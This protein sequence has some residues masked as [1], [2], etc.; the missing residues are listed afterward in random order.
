MVKSF[1]L[2]LAVSTALLAGVALAGFAAIAWWQMRDAKIGALERQIRDQAEREI[3]RRWLADQW[4]RHEYNMGRVFGTLT[5]QQSLLLVQDSQ[6]M[7]FRS[8]HWP[9][10]LAPDKLPWPQPENRPE[11]LEPHDT[12]VS[13]VA[14]PP[15]DG[16]E[17]SNIQPP[18]GMDAQEP[19]LPPPEDL[20]GGLSPPLG[21]PPRPRLSAFTVISLES[22]GKHWRFG[23]ASTPREKLAIG[24]DLAVIEAE[25]TEMRNAFLLA[26]PLALGFIGLGAWFL[27]G[28]ALSPIRS[29]T[30]TM[31]SVTAK[32]LDQRVALRHEDEEFRRLIQVFNGMLERLE[33][34]FLQATRFSGDAAHELKTPLAILQGQIE[35]AM[36]QCEAGS[37]IQTHLTDILDE[38]QRLGTIS[39]KLLLLSLADAGRL[40]LHVIRLDLSQVLE[41]LLED[42]QMLA[43]ELDVSGSIA[44]GLMV[45]ADAALLRQVLHNLLGNAIKY[46][47][48]NGWIRISASLDDG[49]V[50]VSIVNSSAGI[51]QADHERIFER[52]YRADPAHNR[53]VEGAGLGLSLSREIVRAH[54]GDLVLADSGEG[55]VR[56]VVS[57]AL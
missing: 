34:S 21:P 40:R 47:L 11:P 53:Q 22:G 48:P 24:V 25:M 5:I 2:R 56:F 7:V 26:A 12:G 13:T 29:L 18:P 35:R 28:H 41:D 52:F 17:P 16:M 37:P 32:G 46:N 43:P 36:A 39:R 4:T 3:S 8:K 23:L 42:A 31:E 27:S 15:P 9:E 33:R 51:P 57:L 6:G 45:E 10:N 19:P 49:R 38:V 50:E 30:A 14:Y 55:E 1:R 20:P 44:P 54:G